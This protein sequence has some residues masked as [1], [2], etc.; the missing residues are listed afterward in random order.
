MPTTELADEAF[1]PGGA[2]FAAFCRSMSV[3][4]RVPKRLFVAEALGPRLLPNLC[5][6]QWQRP[7]RLIVRLAGTRVCASYGE[8]ITGRELGEIYTGEAIEVTR[9]SH[10]AALLGRGLR[11]ETVR[12]DTVVGPVAYER[13]M[14]PLADEGGGPCC[15]ALWLWLQDGPARRTFRSFSIA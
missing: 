10:L 2:A 15:L 6:M 3:D 7:D 1:S 5:I 12:F 9:R 13:L 14:Q 8:E 4:G 11:A